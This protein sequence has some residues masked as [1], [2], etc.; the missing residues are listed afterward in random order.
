MVLVRLESGHSFVCQSTHPN[1]ARKDIATCPHCENQEPVSFS[2]HHDSGDK[3]SVRCPACRSTFSIAR[4]LYEDQQERIVRSV[5]LDGSFLGFSS[6]QEDSVIGDMPLPPY[7]L[8]MYLAEGNVKRTK[9]V[10]S[11]E[12]GSKR[13]HQVSTGMT[14][15]V[16]GVSIT[17]NKGEI[18]EQIIDELLRADIAFIEPSSKHIQ[19]GDVRLARELWRVCGIHSHN[20]QLPPGW[21]AQ[22]NKWKKEFLAGLLDGDGTEIEKHTAALDTA[23]WSLV[24]QVQEIVR[25]LGGWSVTYATTVTNLTRHQGYRVTID[26]PFRLLSVKDL[27][28]V[29]CNALEGSYSRVAQVKEI[30]FYADWT[31]DLATETKGFSASGI[32]THNSFHT[33][34]VAASRGGGAANR[35]DRLLQILNPPEKL[36][37]AAT[38]S[39][40]KGKIQKIER[41]KATKGWN[42]YV[43][44]EKHFAPAQ[45]TPFHRGKPLSIGKIIQRGDALTDG[46]INPRDLLPLTDVPTVQRY[47]VDELYN[48]IYKDERVRRRNIETV[49]RSLTN[50]AQ[51]SD[52]G[53]SDRLPGDYVLRT[54]IEEENRKAAP[55]TR[56]IEA[57]PI[58]KGLAQGAL[59]QQED[60]MA[61]LNF[62]RLKDTLMQGASKGWKTNIHGTNPIPAYAFGS[63]FG[64]GPT[65]ATY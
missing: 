34:G 29:V 37:G 42:I 44:G 1:W 49:V 11:V 30:E 47:M 52:G 7:L 56:L 16:L 13:R 41:D 22:D 25:S 20:K 45:R 17:Q 33:G 2:S 4:S 53:D 39:R 8:G 48:G 64:K 6:H 31:Y 3:T 38:L 26:L 40:T 5:D 36:P 14:W 21:A 27:P 60:W 43:G 9:D 18:R 51:V 57:T 62:R 63:Q 12:D 46:L 58:L 59:D 28:S 23:S 54:I 10:P 19:L 15:K 35:L 55:G 65:K 50:L 24:C 61:R 32:R